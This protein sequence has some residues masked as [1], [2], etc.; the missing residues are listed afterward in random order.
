MPIEGSLREIALQDI[1]QLVHLS[2]KTGDLVVVSEPSKQRGTL[3]FDGGAVV[4]CSVEGVTLDLGHLLLNSG[5]ITQAELDHA[6]ELRRSDPNRSWSEIFRSSDVVSQQHVDKFQKF[7]VEEFVYEILAW[8]DGR[9]T[10]RER[11]VSETE[12]VTWIPVNSL[13]M[14][15]A[16]R[17]DEL[18]ALPMTIDSPNAVPR[19]SESAVQGGVLD[20]APEQWEVV[21]QVDGVTDVKS[22]AWRLGRSEFDVSK[23]V[24]TLIQVG[25][26][27]IGK[28]EPARTQPPQE[29]ALD[30]VEHL[31]RRDELAV[32][33]EK[34]ASLLEKHPDEPR[35]HFLHARVLQG[36]RDLGGAARGYEKTLELD[37]LAE[38]ARRMLG[39]V[40]LK[41]GDIHGATR[42]WTAYLRMT[43]D[44]A[45]R[46]QV[47]RAMTALRELEV[48]MDEFDGR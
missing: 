7:Q 23:V 12:C 24:S 32:A 37:P 29:V 13:L 18:S 31:I 48:V 38:E 47:E 33:E 22:I 6:S 39:H 46:R 20:L 41:L 36:T 11:A 5:A 44:T 25:L 43:G 2:R 4:G 30:Q 9:F 42:E 10:F 16:R 34:I 17:A 28:A 45:E 1:F 21:A 35:A 15:S 40:K 27:E 3:I 8:Q 14:E 26:L 19:L